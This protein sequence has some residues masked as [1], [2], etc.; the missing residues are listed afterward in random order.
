MRNKE[1]QDRPIDE[2]ESLA[3]IAQMIQ[4]TQQKLELGSGRIFLSWGYI[5]IF[6]TIAV[7]LALRI[8]NNPHWNY[9]WFAIP[10]CGLPFII[11]RKRNNLGVR[12]YIDKII[13][14]VWIV[15]GLTG[16]LL[17]ALSIFNVMWSFPILFIIIL[18]MSIGSILTGLIIEFKP[19]VIGGIL[20]ILIGAVHYL[21]K[22]Y[23]VK[24]LTFALAFLVMDVI[25]GHMLNIKRKKN[26]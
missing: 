11:L 12:T 8:T 10:V 9:L 15:L 6:T 19:L 2:K 23:D 14:Q 17:S 26:V 18:I 25:P 4:N 21:I 16:F 7:W 22:I 3:L 20:A 1:M 13:K 5:T 24:M